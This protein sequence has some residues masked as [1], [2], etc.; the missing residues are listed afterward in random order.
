[1]SWVCLKGV[2]SFVVRKTSTS[3][4][5]RPAALEVGL[6]CRLGDVRAHLLFS[7]ILKWRRVLSESNQ[8]WP[9]SHVIQ[10]SLQQSQQ[11]NLLLTVNTN[12][13]SQNPDLQI[14]FTFYISLYIQLISVHNL[15]KTKTCTK[16]TFLSYWNFDLVCFVYKHIPP[17]YFTLRSIIKYCYADMDKE[18]ILSHS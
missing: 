5:Q 10:R 1:M 3:C 11:P 12:M 14:Q 17:K 13:L 15:K 16:N 18:I 4:S 9:S 8:C 7:L 6:K 2:T